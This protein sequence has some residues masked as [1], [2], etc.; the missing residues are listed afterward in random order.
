MQSHTGA[1]RGG[2]KRRGEIR[3]C[4]RENLLDVGLRERINP[5]HLPDEL[6]G[7]RVDC[8]LGVV[9]SGRCPAYSAQAPGRADCG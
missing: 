9:I 8:K 1:G 4:A 5:H 3:G 7:G 2:G 6:L